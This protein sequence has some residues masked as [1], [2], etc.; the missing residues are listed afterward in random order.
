MVSLTAATEPLWEG[1]S[2][3]DIGA[4]AQQELKQDDQKQQNQKGCQAKDQYEG[5]QPRHNNQSKAEEQ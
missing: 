4:R 2:H 3:E 1:P 5:H